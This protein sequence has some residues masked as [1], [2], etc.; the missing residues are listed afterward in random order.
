MWLYRTGNDSRAPIILYDYHP[1]RNGD[2]A[3]AYLRGFKGYVHSDGYTGYNKL[4]GI[5]RCGCW[6]HLRRKFVEAI[7]DKRAA[8]ASPTSAE[9]ERDCCN[10]L[11]KVE[12]S[13]KDLTPEE[14]YRKRLELEKPLLESFGRWLES[15]NVLKGSSLGK[16]LPMP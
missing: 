4:D 5:T 1:S 3:V 14:R 10:R 8:D 12:E 11:F 7:P 9:I 2:N 16:L 15:L 13:L 6:A